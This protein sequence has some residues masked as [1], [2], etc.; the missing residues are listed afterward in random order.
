LTLPVIVGINLTPHAA[1]NGAT[2]NRFHISALAFQRAQQLKQGA[3]P[4][5]DAGVHKIA[6]VAV[7]EVL[8]DTISW[9]TT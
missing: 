2:L 8:A 1:T 4:R 5:V 7:M 6:T 3:R 9:S